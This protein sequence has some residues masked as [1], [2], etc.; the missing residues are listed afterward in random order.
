VHLLDRLREHLQQRHPLAEDRSGAPADLE[1]RA[2]TAVLL[3]EAAYG[4]TE[5]VWREHRTIVKALERD[6]GLGRRE[7]LALLGR[8]NEIRPPVVKLADVTGVI[9]ERFSAAQRQEVARLVWSVVAADGD[10]EAWEESFADHIGRALALSREQAR[11]ARA[12]S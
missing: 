6:F 4:N 7:I 9:Q 12:G 1:L 2:A 11:A 10:V 3:L 8:A 5:Y